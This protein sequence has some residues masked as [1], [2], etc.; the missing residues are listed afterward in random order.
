MTT[1]RSSRNRLVAAIAALLVLA[2]G[3]AT[4]AHRRDELLHAARLAIDPG[5]LQLELDLVPGIAVVDRV[6]P[7]VDAN[8]DGIIAD[9]EAKRYADRVL[10]AITLELDGAPLQLSMRGVEMPPIASMRQGEG[11]I[12]INAGASLPALAAGDHR[13][14]FRNTHRQDI[15]VYLANALVPASHRIAITNQDRDVDQR[16][17]VIRYRL[18]GAPAVWQPWFDVTAGLAVIVLAVVWRRFRP[19]VAES[20]TR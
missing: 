1:A 20:S 18:S 7:D 4:S 3:T 2:A 17:L 5:Y 14:H 10:S 15:G 12:R 16:D 6:L 19:G 9:A 8:G 13:L 11:V